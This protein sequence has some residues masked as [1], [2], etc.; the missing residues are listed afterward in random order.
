MYGWMTRWLKDEGQGDPIAEPAHEVEM[1]EDLACFPDPTD[2][3]KG[4]LFP[5]TLA[6]REAR[7]VLEKLTSSKPDHAED[8]ESTAVYR[9]AQ[10][11]KQVFGD[12]PKLPKPVVQMGKTETRDKVR[13]TPMVFQPEPD[14]PV[15]ALLLDKAE[16]DGKQ[17]ACVLLHLDGKSE[18]VKHP[19]AA[20][21][22]DKGFAVIAPDLR[23]TGESKPAG[24]LIHDAADHNSAEHGLWIGRPLLGQWVFDVLCILDW[25]GI[26]PGLNKRSFTVAG[27]G[28]SGLVALSAAALFDDR[29]TAAVLADAPISLVTDHAYGKNLRMGPLAPGLLLLGDVPHLAAMIAPRRLAV[30][31]GISPQGRKLKADALQEA[32]AF[33]AAIYK[34]AKAADKLSV[35]ENVEYAT[36]AGEW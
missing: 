1:V 20:A 15:H 31:G 6:A 26:Q 34:V 33:T 29:V 32:F 28:P 10:L 4:F 25:M 17:K 19:L 3:P 12:F 21:L 22:L 14:L 23:A 9:R 30:A 36:L 27:I 11:R 7:A 8:W 18:A 5:P 16:V 13:T 24:D 2:R 35:N